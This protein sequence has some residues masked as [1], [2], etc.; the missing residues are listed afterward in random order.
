MVRRPERIW[1][2][3]NDLVEVDY[4][5]AAG[6][7]RRR[8]GFVVHVTHDQRRMKFQPIDGMLRARYVDTATARVVARYAL[9]EVATPATVI[10]RP[11]RTVP[12]PGVLAEP[13]NAGRVGRE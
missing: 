11:L 2:Q 7:I 5:L 8:L 3:D 13:I 1:P 9:G 4:K 10:Q 6:V 12:T